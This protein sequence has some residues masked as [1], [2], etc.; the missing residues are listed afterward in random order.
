MPTSDPYRDV[1]NIHVI[2]GDVD[3]IMLVLQIVNVDIAPSVTDV[4]ING[5][6]SGIT[7]YQLIILC[8]WQ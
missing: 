1:L 3:V 6:I 2:E 5:C 4:I 8:I 7:Y